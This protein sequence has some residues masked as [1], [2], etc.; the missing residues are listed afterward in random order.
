MGRAQTRSFLEVTPSPWMVN[1]VG[2]S[3]KGAERTTIV[4]YKGRVWV[5]DRLPDADVLICQV[6]ATRRGDVLRDVLLTRRG[7]G[8]WCSYCGYCVR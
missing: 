3:L 2:I 8:M 1:L 7:S 5:E 6:S 4:Y